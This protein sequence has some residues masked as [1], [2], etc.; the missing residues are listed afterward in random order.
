MAESRIADFYNPQVFS[1]TF[2]LRQLE[3]NILITSGV[4]V[5]D[6]VLRNFLSGEGDT[7]D[8]RFIDQL[9]YTAPNESSDNPAVTSTANKMTGGSYKVK[10]HLN[11]N[12]WAAMNI[13]P[14]INGV[15]PAGYVMDQVMSYWNRASEIKMIDSL[16]GVMA[17]NIANDNKD[18]VKDISITTGTITDANRWNYDNFVDATLTMGDNDEELGMIFVNPIVY[19]R[20][21]KS[22]QIDFIP[23]SEGNKKI[24]M[25][26]GMRLM[27][28]NAMPVD[29]SV[30]GYPVYTSM[31]L[32]AGA[33]V[34]D[35]ADSLKRPSAL[36]FD[37][38]A[39]N[40]AG[41]E[42]FYS[43]KNL[44]VAPQGFSYSASSIV[45]ASL[46]AA[47]SWNR[48]VERGRIKIAF[49]RTNG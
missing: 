31:I 49:F 17:D 5:T 9:A 40:G 29:T 47:G 21:K 14:S 3:K 46:R 37:E 19:G 1:D 20:I 43:R 10:K 23:A 26:Q 18:M 2:G 30:S 35:I 28:S 34:L 25:Y 36:H 27:K 24:E 22:N 4:A 41:E 13:L 32:G 16:L 11:N 6:P 42:T 45:E 44:I 8:M 39:G 12:S 38:S 48:E 33:F 7:I 15:D